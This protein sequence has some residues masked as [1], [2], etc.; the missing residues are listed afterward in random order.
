MNIKK[1]TEGELDKIYLIYDIKIDNL[2]LKN[3]LENLFIKNYQKIS[4][5]KK[6]YRSNAFIVKVLGINYAL[7]KEICEKIFIYDT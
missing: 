3:H 1:L 7:D 2:K 6:S 5:K 4:L